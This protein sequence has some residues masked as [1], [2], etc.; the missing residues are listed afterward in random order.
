MSG[1]KI[2]AVRGMH[3]I[4]PDSTPLW[5]HVE[6]TLVRVIQSYGYSEIRLPVVEKTE[7]FARSIGEY[8]DIVAKEMY[9]FPDRNGEQLTLRPEGT[10]GCV[11]AGLEHGLF[12][13]QTQKLWYMGPMFRHERPQK[14]RQRQFHQVGIEAFGLPGPDI[15]AE[16]IILCGRL[17]RELGL[18]GI[19]LELN[20]LGTPEARGKYRDILVDYLDENRGELDEDSQQRLHSNPLR[21]LDS[22]NP[23]MQ[24]L[25]TGAPS[26]QDHLDS[27]SAEHFAELR[28][29]LD[30]AKIDYI[31]NPRLV[32]GLDYYGKTVFEWTTDHL[33]AQGTICAGGRFDNLVEY[34]GGKPVPA[35][36]CAMGMERL[37]ELLDRDTQQPDDSPHAYFILAGDEAVANG[38]AIAESLRDEIPGLRLRVNHGGGSFKAQ[39]KRADKSGAILALILGQDELAN[40]TVG[41]K[42]LREQSEQETVPVAKLPAILKKHLE[43][44]LNLR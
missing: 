8:T 13:N 19:K 17:W 30:T 1:S 16:M 32:R 28:T 41:L 34:F 12:H 31:V 23:D 42:S 35:I 20:T 33:G 9:T 24:T 27:E 11:R 25:I 38:F 22:K 5:R 3:D 36:G 15:D 6:N 7:L 29:L 14:G 4:L 44:H 10:A 2:Q 18:S 43:G 40:Q 37:T 26:I 21:V 39:F